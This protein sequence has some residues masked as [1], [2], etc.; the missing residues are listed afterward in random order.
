[1]FCTLLLIQFI[2]KTCPVLFVL[3]VFFSNN[4]AL[5]EDGGL[6]VQIYT[7]SN[8]GTDYQSGFLYKKQGFIPTTVEC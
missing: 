4:I 3:F 8:G 1:M 6:Y 7:L 5:A 2:R